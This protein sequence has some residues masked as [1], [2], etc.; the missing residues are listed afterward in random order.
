MSPSLH[1]RNNIVI[2]VLEYRYCSAGVST[3]THFVYHFRMLLTAKQ[4][5]G[6]CKAMLL[7]CH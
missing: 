1:W 3:M 4:L 5:Q 7:K 6:F 2:A